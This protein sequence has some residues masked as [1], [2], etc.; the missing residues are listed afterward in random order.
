[1]KHRLHVA[2][3]A[4][5]LVLAV[6][7]TTGVGDAAQRAG[8]D[9]LRTV[10]ILAK[11]KPKPRVVRGP[12]GR[13]GARGPAG[14]PGSPGTPG[15]PGSPGSPG[16]PGSS[17]QPGEPGQQ[18]PAG[19]KGTL[20][21]L[22]ELGGLS[23]SLRGRSGRVVVTET[24][25]AYSLGISCLVPDGFEP[26]A[27]QTAARDVS[28]RFGDSFLELAPT[29]F[30]E[31]DEDWFALG[32]SPLRTLELFARHAEVKMDVYRNG[33]AVATGVRIYR[34]TSRTPYGWSV[35]VYAPVGV[36]AYEA[37]ASK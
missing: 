25:A 11:P 29:I 28:D 24:S 12:R 23:C 9:T 13:P 27:T 21:T 37:V 8:R 31:D 20:G 34:E 16:T 15:T 10:G 17:G 2:A 36:T 5:A 30:P 19:P 4:V 32:V 7:G 26:N 6:F 35:R 18:G 3:T 33:T 14:Q 1:V 22:D